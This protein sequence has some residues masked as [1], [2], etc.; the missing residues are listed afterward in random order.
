VH[1]RAY[2]RLGVFFRPDRSEVDPATGPLY[3]ER[4]RLRGAVIDLGGGQLRRIRTNTEGWWGTGPSR[5]PVLYLDPDYLDGTE[6][7]SGTCAIGPGE[8]GQVLVVHGLAA[9]EKLRILCQTGW[10]SPVQV[11][12]IVVGPVLLWGQEYSYGRVQQTT[13]NVTLTTARGGARHARR[14]GP[15]RRSVEFGWSE[16]VLE[17]DLWTGTAPDYVCGQRGG[18]PVAVA[19]DV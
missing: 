9:Y 13:P 8:R 19:R 14:E 7:E 15:A 6:L 10:G 16:G 1:G 4:D 17:R 3:V 2:Q 18:D 5:P 12:T 11:G